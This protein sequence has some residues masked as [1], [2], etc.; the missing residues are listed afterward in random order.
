M[1][2]LRLLQLQL[3]SEDP[4]IA[5]HHKCGLLSY[6]QSLVLLNVR[7]GMND[8]NSVN[9]L[10]LLII[11][12]K[13]P[14]DQVWSHLE[15]ISRRGHLLVHNTW[16]LFL[17]KGEHTAWKELWRCGHKELWRL[18]SWLDLL[19]REEGNRLIT[20]ELSHSCLID[21]RLGVHHNTK[22]SGL[23]KRLL[24]LVH[25]CLRIILI[26]IWGMTLLNFKLKIL[27]LNSSN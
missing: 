9:L 13:V 27:L 1:N 17:L 18:L 26:F 15:T 23:L 22:M 4:R 20:L 10:L 11:V 14:F 2:F 21:D 5:F 7:L 3:V 16:H 8:L 19:L 24:L 6:T 12:D 25:S